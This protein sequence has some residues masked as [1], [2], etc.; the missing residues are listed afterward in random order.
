[1]NEFD[2]CINGGASDFKLIEPDSTENACI[3]TVT[4]DRI[5]EYFY[6]CGYTNED[7]ISIFNGGVNSANVKLELNYSV[8]WVAEKHKVPLKEIFLYFDSFAKYEKIL[9]LFD[10]ITIAELK[11]Q[12]DLE[13]N[14]T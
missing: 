4:N 13:F 6:Q 12:L 1:M 8:R 2:N 7:L 3:E 11:K 9:Y 10:S 14:I 5:R